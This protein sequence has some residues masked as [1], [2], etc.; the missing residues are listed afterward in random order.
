MSRKVLFVH[1]GPLHINAKDEVFGIQFTEEVKQRYLQLGDTVTFCTREKKITDAEQSKYSRILDKDFNFVSFPNFKSIGT[2][3]SNKLK[4]KRIIENQVKKHDVVVVRMPSAS[5][6]MAIKAARAYNIPYLVEMVACTYDAYLFYNWK[7]KL[8][9][10]FKLKKVQGIIKDCSHVIYVTKN[11]LQKRYPTDGL[12]TNVSNVELQVIGDD[13]LAERITK[14]NKKNAPL[15]L[16][17]IGVIDVKYKGQADVIK[18]LYKLK[19]QNLIYHYKIVGSG[20]PM[21]LQ[22]LINK[23]GMAKEVEIVGSLPFSKI[24]NFLKSVDIYIQP[25]KTEGLPR[26]LIEAMGMGCPALG[27]KVGGIPE[28]LNPQCL[29]EAGNVNEIAVM[30]KS[31]NKDKLLKEANANFVNAKQYQKDILEQRRSRFYKQF[32]E[33]NNLYKSYNVTEHI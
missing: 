5:G 3:L 2:Y 17:S 4:S 33:E 12:S 8:I 27:S 10:P 25:S 9:A 31:F 20:N 28:L 32:L 18:A 21:R 13:I 26:A 23:L 7:G 14:I 11:F 6:S 19:A 1:D 22:N 24:N 30:I 15:V 16:A 29:F